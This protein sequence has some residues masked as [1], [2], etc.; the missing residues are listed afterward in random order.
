MST[1]DGSKVS[2]N[3]WKNQV[4]LMQSLMALP[5]CPRSTHFKKSLLY[6]Q[7]MTETMKLFTQL[8]VTENFVNLR[9]ATDDDDSDWVNEEDHEFDRNAFDF[10]VD[11]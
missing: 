6:H 8:E 4:F 10:I 3:G 1:E 2:I 7:L 5:L 11:E 9:L